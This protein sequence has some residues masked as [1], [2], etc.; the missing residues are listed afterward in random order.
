M[1]N[2]LTK[3]SVAIAS[4]IQWLPKGTSPTSVLQSGKIAGFEDYFANSSKH[5]S[6]MCIGLT[7]NHRFKV[8]TWLQEVSN[9]LGLDQHV[10]EVKISLNHSFR[11]RINGADERGFATDEYDLIKATTALKN[12]FV[13]AW[14]TVVMQS[15]ALD[16]Q[17]KIDLLT[18]T[19][20]GNTNDFIPI[21]STL[22]SKAVEGMDENFQKA[23]VIFFPAF[24]IN[25]G[26]WNDNPVRLVAFRENVIVNIKNS[27]A[28]NYH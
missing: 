19:L 9:K 20:S 26:N 13:A 5:L 15:Q 2:S 18:T 7:G 25:R 12:K 17:A 27:L 4:C 28:N 6:S 8:I 11:D 23:K 16:A 24:P 1:N 10:T 14:S 22:F 21:S 3:S